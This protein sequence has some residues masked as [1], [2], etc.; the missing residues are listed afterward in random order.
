MKDFPKH[1]KEILAHTR[2]FW[3]WKYFA[4]LIQKYGIAFIVIVIAWEAFEDAVIPGVFAWL[5][6]VVNPLFYSFMLLPWL[7][8]LG[9]MVVPAVWVLYCKTTRRD[10][11]DLEE[12][13]K[14]IHK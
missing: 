10:M 8:C 1:I 6:H 4:P 12:I 2:Q 7:F 13:K 9:P 5:G 14:D 11:G 3:R